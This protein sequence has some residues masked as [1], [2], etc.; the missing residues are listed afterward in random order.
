MTSCCKTNSVLMLS[1]TPTCIFGLSFVGVGETLG[2]A[3]LNGPTV[4]TPD[5]LAV[6][7]G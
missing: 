1:Q 3:A 6:P 5:E 7:V 2:T 4:P